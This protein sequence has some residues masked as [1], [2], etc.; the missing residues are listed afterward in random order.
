MCQKHM[1]V[2]DGTDFLPQKGQCPVDEV[3]DH[4][5]FM[6]VAGADY[7]RSNEPFSV[8]N[9]LVPLFHDHPLSAA[10]SG[11]FRLDSRTLV[12]LTAYRILTPSTIRLPCRAVPGR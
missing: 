4:Q 5:R 12:S 6:K 7:Q 8:W 9:T 11:A 10:E 2:V 3:D 1:T